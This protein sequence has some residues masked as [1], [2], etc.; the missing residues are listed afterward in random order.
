M[1]H[2]TQTLTEDPT[3]G[4]HPSEPPQEAS[5]GWSTISCYAHLS[6]PATD[7]FVRECVAPLAEAMVGRGEARRWFFLR[8]WQGGPHVRVRFLHA[9]D[10]AL[11]AFEEAAARWLATHDDG[12]LSLQ[13]G[14]FRAQFGVP[15]PQPW[16]Q[17]GRIV[18]EPYLPETERYGGPAGLAACEQF[19]EVSS[20]IAAASLH[21]GDRSRVFT[22]GLDMMVLALR[23]LHPGDD[24]MAARSARRYFLSWDFVAESTTA[25]AA[26]LRHAEA[27][28]PGLALT[29]ARR[30]SAIAEAL[31]RDPGSTHGL[32]REA[33]AG[34]AQQLRQ[35]AE[36]E[37]LNR[38]PE[39]VVWSVIH[40]MNNRLGI[41]VH[42]ERVL[43]W[44]AA[45]A[46]ADWWQT[47]DWF[48][49]ADATAPDRTYLER[50]GY[51]VGRAE[52][53]APRGPG[54]VRPRA[55][56][57]SSHRPPWVD[58]PGPAA[59]TAPLERVLALRA[60]SYGDYGGSLAV[61]DLA[62]VLGRAVGQVPD[63]AAVT[64]VGTFVPRAHPSP[65]GLY[66]TEVLVN[67]WSV[68]GLEP[69]LYR[70]R[71]T[72][73]C[74]ARLGPPL[75]RETVQEASAS[76]GSATEGPPTVRTQ[77]VP[78]LLM[79]T[80]DLSVVRP[81][82]GLRAL[83]LLLQESGHIAQNLALCAAALGCPSLPISAFTDDDLNTAVHVDGIDGFLA[84]L[85]PLGSRTG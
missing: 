4:Q 33:F 62:T 66:A 79:L 36:Q 32:W 60:S 84:A 44:L 70:Y 21:L 38:P 45:R 59:L 71:A 11:D 30:E 15:D 47:G 35:L 10:T 27:L 77:T 72:D 56:G 22:I 19:F 40:M 68:T 50:S 58:L 63:R 48:D 8:Y 55:A 78:A 6:V 28:R 24:L 57:Q 82:Y 61:A 16:Q 37:A 49:E 39:A 29:W 12:L 81:K 26:A 13:E 3:A 74:L 69:G 14:S 42:E 20:R 80:C 43:G 7:V 76:F 51:A 25:R 46:C 5:P 75:A 52:E 34:L 64:P 67:A 17:H 1:T 31:V 83:R 65:G 18:R 41:S 23:E 2:P 73:H 54:A 85:L 9:E 53:Q